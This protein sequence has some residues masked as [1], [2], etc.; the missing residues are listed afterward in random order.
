MECPRSNRAAIVPAVCPFR[1]L[2]GPAVACFTGAVVVYRI[3]SSLS[4]D[5]DDFYPAAAQAEAALAQIF[6][7]EPDLEG[8]LWV[9]RIEL[10][11]SPN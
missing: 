1:P 5:I 10:E 2:V 6:A 8:A 7:D 11:L 9:E 3:A 4:R